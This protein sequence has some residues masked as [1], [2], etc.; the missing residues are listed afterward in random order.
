MASPVS[1][2]ERIALRVMMSTLSTSTLPGADA[3]GCQAEAMWSQL[4][5]EVSHDRLHINACNRVTMLL[6]DSA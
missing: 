5:A 3:G 1:P 6:G 2:E 4:L